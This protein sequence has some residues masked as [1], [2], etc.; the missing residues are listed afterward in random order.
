MNE[1]SQEG[2]GQTIENK[3]KKLLRVYQNLNE[4]QKSEI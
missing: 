2:A 1:N 3:P 4:E